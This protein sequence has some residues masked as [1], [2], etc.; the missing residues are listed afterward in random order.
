MT[1]PE[2]QARQESIKNGVEFLMKRRGY[3]RAQ[4]QAIRMGEKWRDGLSEQEKRLAS[5]Q[6]LEAVLRLIDIRAEPY[7]SLVEDMESQGAF[8]AWVNGIT[9][10]AWEDYVGHSVY[11]ATPFPGDP[12]YKSI[13]DRGRHWVTLGYDVVDAKEKELSQ[14]PAVPAAEI[15][16]KPPV[17]ISYSWDDEMH[18]QWVLKL[19]NRLTR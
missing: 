13:T 6:R 8:M 10:Q 11:Q 9:D 18:K 1:G 14:Q 2:Q 4:A 19:A 12:N 16:G 7:L 3:A 5:P 15:G 17:F